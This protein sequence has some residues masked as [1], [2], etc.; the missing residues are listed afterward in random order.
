MIKVFTK[1]ELTTPAGDKDI[2]Y[3]V[4]CN[5]GHPSLKRRG[6]FGGIFFELFYL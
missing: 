4:M 2:N 3:L 6:N 5:S 1:S